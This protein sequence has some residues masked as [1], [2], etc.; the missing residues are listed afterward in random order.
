MGLGVAASSQLWKARFGPMGNAEHA[1]SN[2]A[3]VRMHNLPKLVV[4]WVIVVKGCLKSK[5][6]INRKGRVDERNRG[7]ISF[8][9]GRAANSVE[10]I[11]VGDA[12]GRDLF[13]MGNGHL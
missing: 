10:S 7:E 6:G 3:K 11:D 2:P 1:V 8:W 12:S 13:S 9:H 4:L 5:R